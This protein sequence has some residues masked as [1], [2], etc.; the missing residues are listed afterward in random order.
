MQPGLR[1]GDAV[2]VRRLGATAAAS[3]GSLIVFEAPTDDRKHY[4]KRVI[5]RP[6]DLLHAEDGCLYLNGERLAEPYL[7][8]L[9]SIPGLDVEWELSLDAGRYFV[10]GDN[11]LGSTDSRHFGPVTRDAI[12]GRVLVRLW[13]PLALGLV[14]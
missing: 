1:P 9:P 4:L 10:M 3:R 8:G 6:G 14:A 2:L 5:G 13:P 7:G 12:W 11:R